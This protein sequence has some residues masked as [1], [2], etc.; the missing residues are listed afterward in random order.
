MPTTGARG[1]RESGGVVRGKFLFSPK[2]MTIQFSSRTKPIQLAGCSFLSAPDLFPL[3]LSG[4]ASGTTFIGGEGE[5]VGG[6]RRALLF[7]ALLII[8]ERIGITMNAREKVQKEV[9]PIVGNSLP[10][11]LHNTHLPRLLFLHWQT[12][13]E[14]KIWGRK[15]PS[16]FADSEFIFF[17]L[18][19]VSFFASDCTRILFAFWWIFIQV[20]NSQ[21][22]RN[23]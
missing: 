7:S 21:V 20:R 9:P 22:L 5:R 14:A 2:T 18:F 4:R 19:S 3:N 13:S 11:R 1:E 6:R 12:S 8:G 16:N 17:L 15:R 23:H 10:S